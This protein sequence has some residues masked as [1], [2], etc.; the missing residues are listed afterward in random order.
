MNYFDRQ[1]I[2]FF[3]NTSY[4]CLQEVKEEPRGK[5]GFDVCGKRMLR[6]REDKAVRLNSAER[7]GVDEFKYLGT[8]VR[9]NTL[10]SVSRMEMSEGYITSFVQ[11]ENE[12]KTEG[13]SI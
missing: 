13:E 3:P 11:Q 4:E 7:K 10:K 12:S 9:R 5:K 6:Y 1:N 8:V 2:R